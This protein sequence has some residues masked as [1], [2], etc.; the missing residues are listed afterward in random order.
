MKLIEIDKE[1][2]DLYNLMYN[3]GI[4][5]NVHIVHGGKK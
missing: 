1:D 5:I 4:N 2:I 3:R